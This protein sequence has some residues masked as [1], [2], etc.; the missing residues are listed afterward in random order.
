MSCKSKNP[1]K[2]FNSNEKMVALNLPPLLSLH[3]VMVEGLFSLILP[4]VFFLMLFWTH[5]HKRFPSPFFRC[6]PHYFVLFQ[7]LQTLIWFKTNYISTTCIYIATCYH[8]NLMTLSL[9]CTMNGW[10]FPRNHDSF[11]MQFQPFH[12]H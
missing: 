2:T 4:F 8:S 7:H 9:L 10:S 1:W 3:G 5:P 11:L 12:S 6:Q